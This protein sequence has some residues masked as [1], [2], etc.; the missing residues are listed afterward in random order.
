MKNKNDLNSDDEPEMCE[1]CK[2]EADQA[3]DNEILKSLDLNSQ[4]ELFQVKNEDEVEITKITIDPANLCLY[5][6]INFYTILTLKMQN[7]ENKFSLF[8]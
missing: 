3:K 2:K 6:L 5:G 8:A 7:M 1:N 4:K